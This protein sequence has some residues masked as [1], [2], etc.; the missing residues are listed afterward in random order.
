V[1]NEHLGARLEG[2]GALGSVQGSIANHIDHTLLKPEATAADIERLCGEAREHRFAA[3]CVNGCWVEACR[4]F[5][6]GSG[7]KTATVV[8]F[9]LGAT[10][11]RAKACEVRD[12]VESG[13]EELDVV[14]PLGHIIADDWSYVED[15][16]R[17]VV[18]AAAGRIVKV[19]LET[20]AL[21]QSH[22]VRAAEFAVQSGAHFVKTST[23]FHPAGGASVSAVELLRR[24][25]GGRL[26]IKAAGGIRD[27]RTALEMLAAGAT[28]LG[29]SR[30]VDLLGSHSL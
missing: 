7:V 8:G 15:D 16:L 1:T 11:T 14:A 21:D 28:R 5:L 19:I 25:V 13:A 2:D 24:T 26:G 6:S 20:A 30:G 23:G 22:I 27:L 17:A 4:G 18:D 3:V 12:L 10:S 9:P 29:T